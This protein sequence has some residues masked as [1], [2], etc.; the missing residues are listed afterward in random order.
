MTANNEDDADDND[1]QEDGNDN[2]DNDDDAES[3]FYSKVKIEA[4]TADKKIYYWNHKNKFIDR[5]WLF[6]QSHAAGNRNNAH[7]SI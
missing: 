5:L 1:D 2:G 3:G 4:T 7:E 6:L